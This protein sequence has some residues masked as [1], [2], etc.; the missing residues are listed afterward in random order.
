MKCAND[1]EPMKFLTY[2]GKPPCNTRDA[3]CSNARFD[4]VCI[5]D[6]ASM[7]GGI[8]R[9]FPPAA[10]LMRD[11][12]K[13]G[14]ETVCLSRRAYVLALAAVRAGD[15]SSYEARLRAALLKGYT[16]SSALLA[17]KAPRF[18]RSDTW[19]LWH[20]QT[21]FF[22]VEA[23]FAEV[24]HL[25]GLLVKLLPSSLA[26]IIRSKG[27]ALTSAAVAILA[28]QLGVAV[29]STT[30]VAIASHATTAYWD[31]LKKSGLLPPRLIDSLGEGSS[32]KQVLDLLMQSTLGFSTDV[33]STMIQLLMR[34]L[35]PCVVAALAYTFDFARGVAEQ[36]RWDLASSAL[37][38]ARENLRPGTAKALPLS[39]LNGI[40]KLADLQ[41]RKMLTALG[42]HGVP[43][44]RLSDSVIVKE[45]Q[46]LRDSPTSGGDGNMVSQLM[47]GIA[48][49]IPSMLSWAFGTTSATAVTLNTVTAVPLLLYDV[50]T[51][52]REATSPELILARAASASQKDEDAAALRRASLLARADLRV[53]L[54]QHLL[55]AKGKGGMHELTKDVSCEYAA[56]TEK[57]HKALKAEDSLD[58]DWGFDE[59]EDVEEKA[60]D[61]EKQEAAKKA[62]EIKAEALLQE[63]GHAGDVAREWPTYEQVELASRLLRSAH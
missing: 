56:A 10:R 45:L 61:K 63:L 19:C 25:Q 11:S 14:I 34:V 9:F 55:A 1:L 23:S 12:Q 33:R 32:L 28:T 59:E 27:G 52:A 44:K 49:A 13:N 5:P 41:S 2:A 15:P 50:W 16:L 35:L 21:V 57:L 29:V 17:L 62:A 60:D 38:V 3:I 53:A 42:L 43:P 4:G 39:F 8:L 58:I 51:Q 22:S 37:V 6:V 30:L 46:K 24:G 7:S 36:R 18:P 40:N 20:D 48:H 47:S 54:A 26:S 31:L